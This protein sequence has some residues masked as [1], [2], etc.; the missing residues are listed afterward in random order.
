MIHHPGVTT[1]LA[2]DRVAALTA[3]AAEARLAKQSETPRPVPGAGRGMVKSLAPEYSF[4]R[5]AGG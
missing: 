4:R 5:R 2:V 3:A 1:A